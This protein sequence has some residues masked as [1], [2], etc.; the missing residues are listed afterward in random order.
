M[1]DLEKAIDEIVKNKVHP[2]DL[3]TRSKLYILRQA[4]CILKNEPINKVIF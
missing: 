1:G 4:L 3:E 2:D